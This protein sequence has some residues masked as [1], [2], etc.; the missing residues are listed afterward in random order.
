MD[1]SKLISF[2]R[3]LIAY[4][5]AF[6]GLA[7]S[8]AQFWA[9]PS[10]DHG[11]LHLQRYLLWTYWPELTV[12]LLITA[13]VVMPSNKRWVTIRNF[14]GSS[15]TKARTLLRELREDL[16]LL[17]TRAT[18]RSGLIRLMPACFIVLG[19]VVL[20]AILAAPAAKYVRAKASLMLKYPMEDFLSVLSARAAERVE[21]FDYM[22]AETYY[23]SIQSYYGATERTRRV[24]EELKRLEQLRIHANRW[25]DY[26]ESVESQSGINRI[27][28]LN[29]ADALRYLPQAGDVVGRVE[30]HLAA[31]AVSERVQ[32][33]LET[34]CRGNSNA[35]PGELPRLLKGVP[36][37]FA[38]SNIA[39]EILSA[40]ASESKDAP[41]STALRNACLYNA[42]FGPLLHSAPQEAGST[43]VLR[44][45][46]QHRSLGAR[47][48]V[49]DDEAEQQ[50]LPEPQ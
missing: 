6:S 33:R 21:R 23:R 47:A 39:R 49:L 17:R 13:C 50:E 19:M 4:A 11:A 28:F 3:R 36:M 34:I 7:A 31:F 24:T 35:Q 5:M 12:G 43:D 37:A 45:L 29:Y 44:H 16:P 41:L 15:K 46:A 22:G 8:T 25:V 20:G 2:L 9:N 26:A 42:K 48:D 30:T 27:S 18:L 1:A 14:V 38:T 32:A 10:S 40:L